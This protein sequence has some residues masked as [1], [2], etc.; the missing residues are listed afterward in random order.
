MR[1]QK[2]PPPSEMTPNEYDA[3]ALGADLSS[4]FGVPLIAADGSWNYQSPGFN[5]Q[6]NQVFAI[7]RYHELCEKF[8]SAL[9]SGAPLVTRLENV[10]VRSPT[11]TSLP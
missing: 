11:T 6:T 4:L 3:A 10:E 9:A 2:R 1:K 8:E 5:Y 7:E